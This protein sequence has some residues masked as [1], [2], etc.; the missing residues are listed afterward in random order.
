M[1]PHIWCQN[2]AACTKGSPGVGAPAWS[3]RA[4]GPLTRPHTKCARCAPACTLGASGGTFR[5]EDAPERSVSGSLLML[6]RSWRSRWHTPRPFA[7]ASW[8]S[9]GPSWLILG[10]SWAHRWARPETMLELRWPPKS[11]PEVLFAFLIF[12]GRLKDHC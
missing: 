3:G 5:G 7:N 4:G 10:S 12:I 1:G 8:T 9:L 2:Q 11:F 6:V